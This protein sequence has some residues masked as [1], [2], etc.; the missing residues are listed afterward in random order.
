[1]K[2]TNVIFVIFCV[3]I[4]AGEHKRFNFDISEIKP[5]NTDESKNGSCI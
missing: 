5:Q 4:F 2:Y 3:I 1:M